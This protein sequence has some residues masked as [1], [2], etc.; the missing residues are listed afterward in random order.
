MTALQAITASGGLT[1]SAG[2]N[3]VV[4][5]RRDACGHAHD[6]PLNLR[7]ALKQKGHQDDVV[8]AP[9]DLLIV[10]RSGIA[11]AGLF[12]KQYISDL[13][14]VKPYISAPMF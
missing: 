7:K 9:T 13:L 6:E 11:A 1:D 14:P 5:V 12:V 3:K 4:L 2:P 8:L 10:P